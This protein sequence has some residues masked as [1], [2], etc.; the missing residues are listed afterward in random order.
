MDTENIIDELSDFLGIKISK[1][2]QMG[3]DRSVN[4]IDN[5]SFHDIE[6]LFDRRACFRW[7]N[8]IDCDEV[9]YCEILIPDL[10]KRLGYGLSGRKYTIL[11]Y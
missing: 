10:L 7:M 4:W 9:K 6:K 2:V 1:D 8:N 5:S 3:K 11:G